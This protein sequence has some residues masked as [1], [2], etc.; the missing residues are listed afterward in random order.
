MIV[1]YD[2]DSVLEVDEED[3]RAVLHLNDA[4]LSATQVSDIVHAVS[5]QYPR[6]ALRGLEYVGAGW[7]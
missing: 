7:L 4:T 5:R 3:F 6:E 2:D 1:T